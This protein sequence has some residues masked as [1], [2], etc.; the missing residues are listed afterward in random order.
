MNSIGKSAPLV[1][2]IVPVFNCEKYV[3]ETLQSIDN[4]TYEKIEIIV[5][6][7]GSTDRTAQILQSINIDICYI[8][9]ANQGAA[10]ARKTGVDRARGEF[11]TFLDSDDLWRADKVEKQSNC[12]QKMPDMDICISHIKN[13]WQPELE[14][15]RLNYENHT[16]SQPMPGYSWDTFMA[17]LSIFSEVGEINAQVVHCDAT[18][19]FLRAQ[20]AGVKIHVLEDVLVWRRLHEGNLSRQFRYESRKEYLSL[21]RQ[22]LTRRRVNQ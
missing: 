3:L 22:S 7:D 12:F 10:A 5:V 2:C 11:I 15:E 8:K 16:I 1:S 20:H 9:Q 21:V 14:G 4:Q 6:D 19:F 17:R 13:F 18:E